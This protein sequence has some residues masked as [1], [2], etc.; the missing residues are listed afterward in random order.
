MYIKN[1]LRLPINSDEREKIIGVYPYFGPTGILGYINDYKINEEF[2]LIGEDGDHFLKHKEREM[3]LVFN[4]KANV[5]N[6]AH[7][8]TNS[9]RCLV[10]WFHAFFVHRD[11]TSHLT[12]QGAKRYKLTKAGLQKLTLLLPPIDEQRKIVQILSIWDKAIATTE[13]LLGNSQQQKKALLQQL[14]TGKKRFPEFSGALRLTKLN[15]LLKEEKLRNQ[16]LLVDRV[17]S[18][19][20]HSGF[21]LPEDQFSKRVASENVSNYKIVKHGQYGYNP[22]RLNIGS[23]AKLEEYDIGILSPM[24]VVFSINE[25]KL[26]SD[27]FYN[28]MQSNEAKQRIKKST[29]GS[30][31]ESV[32][33][34]ALTSFSIRLPAL[35]EQEN[36]ASVLNVA[37]KEIQTLKSKLDFLKEEKKALMQQLLTGKKRVKLEG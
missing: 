6:H 9:K 14:L 30:V 12:R 28:W 17:L 22:S 18:V 27:Y 10:S 32:G 11:I 21:V 15:S 24:Y 19:T 3:T 23:F 36:I 33:F 16:S 26:N 20:N 8:I 35:D 7:I 13:K 4:G 1:N 5:N 2:A 34:D 29:Q 31:R 37:D 25:D